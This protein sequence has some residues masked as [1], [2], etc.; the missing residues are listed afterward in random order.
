LVDRYSSTV[1]IIDSWNGTNG[2]FQFARFYPALNAEFTSPE[3]RQL[4]YLNMA[5]SE[6]GL[7]ELSGN[8]RVVFIPKEQVQSIEIRYGSQAERPLVQGITGLALI[9]LGIVGLSIMATGS[10]DML[11][12]GLGFFV[13]G[14][15]GA[16]LLW[17]VLKR[18]HYLWVICSNDTRKLVFKGT[19]QKTEL[20]GFVRSAAQFGYVF[21]DCLNDKDFN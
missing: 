11:R 10:L 18:G 6:H 14:G 12:W 4:L 20:S 1:H 9:V 17:E 19:I 3:K 16:W 7:T 15:L 5:V 2:F 13:F 8:R 21:R